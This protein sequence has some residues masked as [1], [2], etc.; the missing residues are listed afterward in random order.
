MCIYKIYIYIYIYLLYIYIFIYIIYIFILACMQ[1]KFHVIW[2]HQVYYLYYALKIVKIYVNNN[3][4]K[5]TSSN[6]I[7]DIIIQLCKALSSKSYE[8]VFF[9]PFKTFQPQF[10]LMSSI[11]VRSIL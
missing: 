3:A 5:N 2:N 9:F 11:S 1:L 8:T 10:N 6:E 4:S 7:K